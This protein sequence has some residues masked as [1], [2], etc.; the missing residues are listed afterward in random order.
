M[1]LGRGSIFSFTLGP[2]RVGITQSFSKSTEKSLAHCPSSADKLF[3]VYGI[4]CDLPDN[5]AL[6]ECDIVTFATHLGF[7]APVVSL[8]RGWPGKAYVYHFNEPN[9]W[10]GEWKVTLRMFS[11]L[12]SCFRISMSSYHQHKRMLLSDLLDVSSSL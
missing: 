4:T 6:P 1:F 10:D 7:L 2:R 12:H 3:R 11:T 8:A 9:P 5:I